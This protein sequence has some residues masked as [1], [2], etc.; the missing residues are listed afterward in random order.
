M[1][2]PNSSGSG[3]T[4]PSP[5]QTFMRFLRGGSSNG[6]SSNGASLPGSPQQQQTQQFTPSAPQRSISDP[7]VGSPGLGSSASGGGT[8]HR[9]HSLSLSSGGLPFGVGPAAWPPRPEMQRARSLESAPPMDHFRL[10]D[11]ALP[12]SAGG[13]G[14]GVHDASP[15]QPFRSFSVNSGAP[16]AEAAARKKSNGFLELL[17]SQDSFIGND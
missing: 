16:I 5:L 9:P 12:A 15:S 4:P 2:Q 17:A 1:S 13:A 3:N 11:S 7:I 6:G 14:Q 10:G 8:H